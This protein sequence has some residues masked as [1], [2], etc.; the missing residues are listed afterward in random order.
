VSQALGQPVVV[1]TLAGGGG[2]IGTNRVRNSPPDGYTLLFAGTAALTV[3]PRL[4]PALGYSSADSR[5][6]ATS[7]RRR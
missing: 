2:G 4:Q 3:V 7:S 1:D 5:R 6:S